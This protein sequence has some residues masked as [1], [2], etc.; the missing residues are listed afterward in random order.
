MDQAPARRKLT[1]P[2]ADVNAAVVDWPMTA[3][4]LEGEDHRSLIELADDMLRAWRTWSDPE[5][6]ILSES[7]GMMHNTITPI[8]RQ[9]DGRWCL[10]LVLRNNRT[11]A[12]HPL[13]IFHPHSELHHIKRENIGLI[14]VM[15]LFIL[16]GRLKTELAALVP[17]LTGAEALSLPPEEDSRRKH[18]P[19]AADILQRNG[20]CATEEEAERLIH[21]ELG[22]VCAQVLTDAGVYKA[23][24]KGQAGLERFLESLGYH[25]VSEL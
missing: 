23:D 5:L 19:W 2:A 10:T 13:G 1:A 21:H 15:G 17:W 12:E 18:Y 3:I 24:E 16:P 20:P 9:N 11:S 25:T 8:L 4:R 7:D 6:D 14:E 22:A